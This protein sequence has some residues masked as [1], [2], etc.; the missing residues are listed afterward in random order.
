MLALRPSTDDV[1][2]IAKT[3]FTPSFP[4]ARGV[5]H[6]CLRWQFD[7][8]R[9]VG[10]KNINKSLIARILILGRRWSTRH[11]IRERKMFFFFNFADIIQSFLRQKKLN[12]SSMNFNSDQQRSVVLEWKQV[13][14]RGF[15]FPIHFPAPPSTLERLDGCRGVAQCDEKKNVMPQTSDF[16]VG[17]VLT[18]LLP[19]SCPFLF[20]VIILNLGCTA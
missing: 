18:L 11:W 9:R 4:V 7:L 12:F 2:Y 8:D 20:Q 16:H 17:T 3:P 5:S 6:Q 10:G 15:Y 14:S 13:A 1:S 19:S